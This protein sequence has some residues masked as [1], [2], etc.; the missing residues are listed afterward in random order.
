MSE[1]VRYLSVCGLARKFF[2]PQVNFSQEYWK[3]ISRKFNEAERKIFR[4]DVR[5]EMP[6]RLSCKATLAMYKYTLF[7]T[8]LSIFSDVIFYK[9]RKKSRFPAG[10]RANKRHP[11]G[12]VPLQ[13]AQNF[14]NGQTKQQSPA[15]SCRP[16]FSFAYRS[17]FAARTLHTPLF[18]LFALCLLL[19]VFRFPPS[20]LHPPNCVPL[21]QKFT[22][23]TAFITFPQKNRAKRPQDMH[24]R[25]TD[26]C[27]ELLPFWPK[28]F[29]IYYN[30]Y[31]AR[32]RPMLSF[33]GCPAA[34]VNEKDRRTV[35]WIR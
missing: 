4:Q 34:A 27:A 11:A 21:S 33:E 8:A 3:C 35:H 16:P 24:P 31:K 32:P 29:I 1:P 18:S 17:L 7:C 14:P 15:C 6:N 22:Q 9:K 5:R 28:S 26:F 30:V 20:T 25:R 12:I 10:P 19:S 23:T 13:A 2:A